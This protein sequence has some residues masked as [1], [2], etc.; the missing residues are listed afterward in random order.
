MHVCL[1][2]GTSWQGGISMECFAAGQQQEGCAGI[3]GH[4]W[5]GDSCWCRGWGLVGAMS[6]WGGLSSSTRLCAGAGTALEG[7]MGS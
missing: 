5:A 3:R 1:C 2:S 4:E 6:T 7:C